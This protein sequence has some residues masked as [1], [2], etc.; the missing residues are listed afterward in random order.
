MT[1]NRQIH[2]GMSTLKLPEDAILLYP[3]CKCPLKKGS[4]KL[5]RRAF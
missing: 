1:E 5:D 4:L 2:S 3:I